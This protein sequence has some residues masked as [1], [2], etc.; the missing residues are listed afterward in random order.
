MVQA[1]EK[2]ARGDL[3]VD[4]S[5]RQNN[6][7]G[8][9]GKAFETVAVDM[10]ELISN[11]RSAAE[12]VA[13]GSRQIASSG[14]NLAQG[15]TQQA[16]AL[17]ELSASVEQLASQTRLNAENASEANSLAA[18]TRDLAERGNNKNERHAQGD[19]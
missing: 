4:V 11:I 3:N 13:V 5:A 19:G 16:S 18:N 1:A 17:E 8:L 10:S 9:L 6:E 7:I 14:M 15:A 12:Q 2:F